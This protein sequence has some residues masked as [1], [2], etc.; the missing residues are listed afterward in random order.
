MY[1]LVISVAVS[2]SLF[3]TQG[4]SISSTMAVPHVAYAMT[5]HSMQQTS[6]FRRIKQPLELKFAVTLGGLALITL[7]I[8][9]FLLSQTSSP[10]DKNT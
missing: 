5:E 1:S 4:S 10:T 6:Q 7:E 3:L 9:W 2:A 8:W